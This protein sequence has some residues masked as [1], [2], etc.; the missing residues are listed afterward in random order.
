VTEH[1]HKRVERVVWFAAAYASVASES[2]TGLF[3]ALACVAFAA[4]AHCSMK[5]IKP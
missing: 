2:V 3:L 1:D 5:A 4:S